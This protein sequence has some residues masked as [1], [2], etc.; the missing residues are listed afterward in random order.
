MTKQPTRFDLNHK[1]ST[2]VGIIGTNNTSNI[3]SSCVIPLSIRDHDMVGCLHKINCKIFVPRSVICRDYSKCDP[4][5]L[6]I[7]IKNSNIN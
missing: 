3:L 4:E 6:G 7:D 5:S 1:T 2:L